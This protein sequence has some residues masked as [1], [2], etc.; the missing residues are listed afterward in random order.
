M[1]ERFQK[2]LLLDGRGHLMGRL[3]SIVAKQLLNGQKVVVVRCEA[4]NI[5]GSFYR[6]KLKY[7]SFLRKR[8]NTNPSRGPFH[9]RA[10]SRIFWRTVRGML[11]HKTKRGQWALD[12]LKVYDGIPPLYQKR[13][14]LVV[15]SAL[16]LMRLNPIRKFA[17]LGRISHE[18]GWKYRGVISTLEVKRKRR[19][20]K[21]WLARKHTVTLR[22][23][24]EQN[25]APKTAQYTAMLQQYGVL[26]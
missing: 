6:N 7:L 14:R 24:A 15:P 3:A 10:P 11:P 5:S 23:R 26:L 1:T 4:I 17:V 9:L 19:S 18:V 2:V 20:N 13:K 12:R 25:V 21:S 16:R 8:M 22:K